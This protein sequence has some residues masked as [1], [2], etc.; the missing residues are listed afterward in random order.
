MKLP[1]AP[2]FAYH[3]SLHLS[4]ISIP[5]EKFKIMRYKKNFMKILFFCP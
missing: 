2:F 3:S 1:G 4:T 5:L